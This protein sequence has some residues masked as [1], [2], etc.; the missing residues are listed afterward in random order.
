MMINIFKSCKLWDHVPTREE[1]LAIIDPGK[2]SIIRK[3]PANGE[4]LA[5][6]L[7]L[8]GFYI[9]YN[10]A[11]RNTRYCTEL[12]YYLNKENKIITPDLKDYTKDMILE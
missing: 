11:V 2:D 4:T 5:N 7:D 6:Y 9:S 12:L 3:L 1:L 8:C 10:G